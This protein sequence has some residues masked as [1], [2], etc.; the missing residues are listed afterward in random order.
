MHIESYLISIRIKTKT[1]NPKGVYFARNTKYQYLGSHQVIHHQNDLNGRLKV[2]QLGPPPPKHPN[3]P[4]EPF[5]LVQSQLLAITFGE[6]FPLMQSQHSQSTYSS[7][8][9]YVT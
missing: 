4:G 1:N 8:Q 6:L 9:R 5:L 2:S 3:R 7:Q